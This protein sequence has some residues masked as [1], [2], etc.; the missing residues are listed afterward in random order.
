MPFRRTLRPGDWDLISGRQSALDSIKEG[1]TGSSL[2]GRQ[3]NRTSGVCLLHATRGVMVLET[4]PTTA[5]QLP[6]GTIKGRMRLG[7]QKLRT[8]IEQETA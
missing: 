5:L 1:I 8:S 6:A 2:W 3:H 7:L 4:Q